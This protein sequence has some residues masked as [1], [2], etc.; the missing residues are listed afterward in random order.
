MVS[1]TVNWWYLPVLL[2]LI[3]FIYN[4]FRAPGGSYDFGF[5]V[6]GVGLVCW[7][8]ALGILFG[9]LVF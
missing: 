4:Y 7:C 2:F 3:P 5:D 6:V 1:V 8:L 9:R